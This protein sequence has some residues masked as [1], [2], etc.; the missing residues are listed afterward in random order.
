MAEASD[1]FTVA[2]T[3]PED[4]AL[5]HFTSGTTGTPKGAL[6]VH[7]AVVTH[8]ATGR[9]ALDLHGRRVADQRMKE[10]LTPT[11]KAWIRRIFRLRGA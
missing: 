10:S 8:F 7:G 3:G 1:T 4:A 2:S 6:H 5:L 11:A 9:Y